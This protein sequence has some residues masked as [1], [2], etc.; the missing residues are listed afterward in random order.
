MGEMKFARGPRQMHF[1]GP[2]LGKN[3]AIRARSLI[4]RPSYRARIHRCDVGIGVFACK[5]RS[6]QAAPGR[7]DNLHLRNLERSTA[8]PG[9]AVVA[10][11]TGPFGYMARALALELA[12]TRVNVISPGWV[13]TLMWDE[14]AGNA[15]QQIWAQMAS[16][17]PA[18]RFGTVA[19]SLKRTFTYWR[20][21]SRPAPC[22]KWRPCAD[23][24]AGLTH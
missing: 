19:D 14:I 4:N 2:Q 22:W 7:L 5:A 11:A 23:L 9:G 3:E 6:R 8:H 16:R 10:A 18:R 17:L 20:A 1:R 13:D 12:P 21:N 15:K 24:S